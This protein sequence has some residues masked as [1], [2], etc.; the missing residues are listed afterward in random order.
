MLF[1]TGMN[2]VDDLADLRSRLRLGTHLVK[3]QTFL[4]GIVQLVEKARGNVNRL[5]LLEVKFLTFFESLHGA[6]ALNYKEGVIRARMAV[7]FII[8]AWLL[9]VKRN[10]RALSLRWPNVIAARGLSPFRLFFRIDHGDF[11]DIPH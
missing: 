1:Q 9:T 5:V 11:A 6:F 2:A 10:M 8:N 3:N 7:Q 4:A